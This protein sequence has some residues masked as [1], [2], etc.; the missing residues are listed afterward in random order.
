MEIIDDEKISTVINWDLP[1]K[2]FKAS[3]QAMIKTCLERNKILALPLPIIPGKTFISQVGII[4]S[5]INCNGC[6]AHCC[7]E[8]I[9]KVIAITRTDYEELKIAGSAGCVRKDEDGDLYLPVP[10]PLLQKS[11]CTVYPNRPMIC[12][13]YP[14]QSGGTDENGRDII[15]LDSRCP[16]ARRITKD[17]Y[18]AIWKIR[19]KCESMK[20]VLREYDERQTNRPL[21][22]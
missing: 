18:L 12:V 6:K 4:L 13:L 2:E 17:A 11:L 9:N 19:T 14:F 20:D 7:R 15:S 3:I 8:S 21:D 1:F 22:R 5:Q 16:E 10:C